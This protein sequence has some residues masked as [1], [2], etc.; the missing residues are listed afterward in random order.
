MRYT[1]AKLIAET[2]ESLN[3]H[4]PQVDDEAKKRF[5]HLREMLMNEE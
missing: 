3:M 4:Y 1:I 2:M 5:S